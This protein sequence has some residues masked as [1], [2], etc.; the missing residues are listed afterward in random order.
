M[1]ARP[2]GAAWCCRSCTP[3]RWGSTARCSALLP[4]VRSRGVRFHHCRRCAQAAR[5]RPAALPQTL[6]ALTVHRREGA[7]SR[8]KLMPS[9]GSGISGGTSSTGR[10]TVQVPSGWPYCGRA[11]GAWVGWDPVQLAWHPLVTHA[12]MHDAR[13]GRQHAGAVLWGLPGPQGPPR[14]GAGRAGRA[15]R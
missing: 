8:A 11:G 15:G 14:W 5:T 13:P 12:H 10:S 1:E 9:T 7:P 4:H 2:A 6:Q 3:P